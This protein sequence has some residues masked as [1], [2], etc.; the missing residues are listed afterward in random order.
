MELYLILPLL[1]F[2]FFPLCVLAAMAPF[3]RNRRITKG[4]RNTDA[5]W[6]NYL[7]KVSYGKQELLERLITLDCASPMQCRFDHRAMTVTFSRNLASVSYNITLKELNG[8][9]YIK[10]SRST[11]IVQKSYIPYLINEFMISNL[12]AEPLP[13]DKYNGII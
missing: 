1:I 7:F 3:F 13:Y 11:F 6:Q 5:N 8:E 12:I 2:V 9:C 4:I 10:I